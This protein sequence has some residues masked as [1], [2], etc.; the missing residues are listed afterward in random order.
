MLTEDYLMRQIS[1]ALAALMAIAG[2]KKTG[3]YQEA[4]QAID[5]AMEQLL[6]MRAGLI[7]SLDDDS[8]V[9][10]LTAQDHA[11][12]ARLALLADLFKEE[13][14]I[15]VA[16][17]HPELGRDRYIRALRFYIEAGLGQNEPPSAELEQKV[18]GLAQELGVDALSDDMLW[19]LFCFSE[20]AGAYARAE[21][22]LLHMLERPGLRESLLP[23]L[24]DYYRRLLD[25]EDEDLARGGLNRSEIEKK[26]NGK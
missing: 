19:A 10:S 3:R 11:E 24:R 20:Q 26:L 2:L 1:Q 9:Q 25:L 23:E 16:Q 13:G 15:H 8:L 7:K 12:T 4:L 17:K 14:D 22:Y 18:E 6:G 21:A 5:Q